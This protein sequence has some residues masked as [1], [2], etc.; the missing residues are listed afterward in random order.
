M[1]INSVNNNKILHEAL[2]TAIGDTQVSFDF[3]SYE[4]NII[5]KIYKN[6]KSVL[7]IMFK[8][9]FVT[10]PEKKKRKNIKI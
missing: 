10:L 1:L 3:A 4:L 5:C 9:F 7:N 8:T 2:K 6:I